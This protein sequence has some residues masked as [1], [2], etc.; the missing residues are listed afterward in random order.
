MGSV[1]EAG[2]LAAW[3]DRQVFTVA[4]LWPY[5]TDAEGRVVYD[6]EGLLSTFPATVNVLIGALTAHWLGREPGGRGFQ[7][8]LM[9][10]SV[11]VVIGHL[12]DPMFVINKRIWTSSFALVSGGWS[13][14]AYCALFLVLKARAFETLMRPL[15]ILGGNAILAFVISQVLSAV[16]EL[17]VGGTTPQKLGFQILQAVVKDPWLASLSCAVGILGLVTLLIRPLHRRG[18]YW[19][20]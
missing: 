16:A 14:L 17:P 18:I 15:F 9:I 6:P 5:G 11:L 13:I 12:L 2:T 3:V 19:R 1:S 8:A 4:H 10:G 20:L 7:Y